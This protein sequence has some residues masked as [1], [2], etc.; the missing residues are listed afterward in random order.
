MI[1]EATWTALDPGRGS[2][3]D[4]DEPA[5]IEPDASASIETDG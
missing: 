3:H 5:D 2:L 4:V 1:D